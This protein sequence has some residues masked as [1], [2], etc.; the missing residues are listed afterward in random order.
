MWPPIIWPP[1]GN[2]DTLDIIE[3]K[4]FVLWNTLLGGWNTQGTDGDKLFANQISDKGVVSR[5]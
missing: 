1:K 5:I 3:L 2:T 4:T